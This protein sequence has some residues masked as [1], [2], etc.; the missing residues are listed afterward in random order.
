MGCKAT[1][2]IPPRNVT[3]S[4]LAQ[5]ILSVK[6]FPTFSANMTFLTRMYYKV[7]SQLLLPLKCLQPHIKMT[8]AKSKYN[9]RMD[10]II[11]GIFLRSI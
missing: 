5:M 11:L 6:A 9:I 4:V 8:L 2:Y 3:T 7:K 10:D 1:Q